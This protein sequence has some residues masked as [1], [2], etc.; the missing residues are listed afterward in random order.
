MTRWQ[1]VIGEMRGDWKVE[2]IASPDSASGH[3]GSASACYSSLRFELLDNSS[4]TIAEQP[5]GIIVT[6]FFISNRVDVYFELVRQVVRPIALVELLV[7]SYACWPR[8][9][10]IGSR[11]KYTEDVDADARDDVGIAKIRRQH[12]SKFDGSR[13]AFITAMLSLY[14][15]EVS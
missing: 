11:Q 1:R 8:A 4:L 9:A 10:E 2:S 5:L 3:S 14:R 6:K 15:R 7:E 13:I 12:M